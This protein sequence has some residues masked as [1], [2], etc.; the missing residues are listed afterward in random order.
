V[1]EPDIVSVPDPDIVKL[2]VVAVPPFANTP[3]IATIPAPATVSVCAVA[4]V[5]KSTSPKLVVPV[6]LIVIVRSLATEVLPLNVRSFEPETVEFAVANVTLLLTVLAPADDAII[7]PP[8]RVRV[9]V[10]SAESLATERVPV[11]EARVT[12]PEKVFEPDNV[13][14]P[15]PDLVTAIFAPPPWFEPSEITPLIVPLFAPPTVSAT[16]VVLA[17]DPLTVPAMSKLTPFVLLSLIKLYVALLVG[18]S[19]MGELKVWLEVTPL[20]ME[21]LP[22]LVRRRLPLLKMN[23]PAPVS[24]TIFLMF[25]DEST[26]TVVRVAPLRVAVSLL[27]VADNDPGG[28]WLPQFAF[29][30]QF[31]SV[32]LPPFQVCEAADNFLV[33]RIASK[34]AAI[35]SGMRFMSG[36]S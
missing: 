3:V 25:R 23:A 5:D 12:P 36:H 4:V 26:V 9:P 15:A 1:F 21:M 22:A 31:E 16:V 19:V 6:L 8:D 18:E 2:P 20:L 33:K 34:L 14:V 24:K 28:V 13:Q 17:E 30:D 35:M 32:P 29:D 27:L 10:P 7:V 11:P